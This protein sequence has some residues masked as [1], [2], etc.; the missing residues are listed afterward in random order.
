M[1]AGMK[2]DVFTLEEGPVILQYPESLSQ[3]SFE[4]LESWLQLVIRKA[5]RSIRT[6]ATEEGSDKR[7]KKKGNDQALVHPTKAS[8]CIMR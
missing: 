8:V 6:E 1:Q 7:L 2:E 4:D 5:K 3:E